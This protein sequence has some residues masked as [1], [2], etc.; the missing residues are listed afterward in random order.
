MRG[1]T[2]AFLG[3]PTRLA[4]ACGAQLAIWDTASVGRI[5]RSAPADVPGGSDAGRGPTMT[6]SP[7]GSS[8]ACV[9]DFGD[10]LLVRPVPGQKGITFDQKQYLDDYSGL[11]P[12]LWVDD[13]D[14]LL[15]ASG[16]SEQ[17]RK[18]RDDLTVWG[19]GWQDQTI[20]D[21]RVA[22]DAARI[23]VVGS[24][25]VVERRNWRTGATEIHWEGPACVTATLSAG[26]DMVA[27]IVQNS[28]GTEGHVTVFDSRTGKEISSVSRKGAIPTNASFDGTRLVVEFGYEST[29]VIWDDLGRGPMTEVPGQIGGRQF[30]PLTAASPLLCFS[31]WQGVILYDQGSREVI[32]TIPVPSG[33]EANR[34]DCEMTPDGSK[35]VTVYESSWLSGLITVTDLRPD[36]LVRV[37]KETAGSPLTA[38]ERA[39]YVS[40]K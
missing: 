19:L 27:L 26:C 6:L 29:A 3:G 31:S 20:L 11:G 21:A 38:R 23:W 9:N 13:H 2:L 35:L 1:E 16:G 7:S 32:G 37:A 22:P 36:T 24:D 39:L 33:R 34:Y 8:L 30:P 5:T 25:G 4:T 28:A 10:H 17:P 40:V 15:P 14:I 18:L 12:P